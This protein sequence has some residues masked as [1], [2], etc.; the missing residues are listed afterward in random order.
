MDICYM[1]KAPRDQ[2]WTPVISARNAT[3]D[4]LRLRSSKQQLSVDRRLW[5]NCHTALPAASSRDAAANTRATPFNAPEETRTTKS[6]ISVM[7]A[8]KIEFFGCETRHH[9]DPIICSSVNVGERK[10][11]KRCFAA[12]RYCDTLLQG[13][14]LYTSPSPRD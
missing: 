10:R 14:L 1:I 6:F 7:D 12:V 5:H 9:S 4:H 3:T 11:R 8:T 2:W 13:C